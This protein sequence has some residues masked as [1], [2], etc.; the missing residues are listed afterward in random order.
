MPSTR[1]STVN[2]PRPLW[3]PVN[4]KKYPRVLAARF[5]GRVAY[6]IVEP[7]SVTIL[8]MQ[9]L[10]GACISVHNAEEDRCLRP[11]LYRD[12][13]EELCLPKPAVT[14]KDQVFILLE[15]TGSPGWHPHVVQRCYI[16]LDD[17]VSPEHEER[18]SSGAYAV[19]PVIGSEP[20]RFSVTG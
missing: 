10:L 3:I 16:T 17:N 2:N 8:Y 13:S 7:D 14:L 20:L 4:Q 19:S 18:R 11:L 6:V 1:R 12:E 5:L 15:K 9:W